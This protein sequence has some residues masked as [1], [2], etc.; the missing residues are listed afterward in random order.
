MRYAT[1]LQDQGS[2]TSTDSSRK[3]THTVQIKKIDQINDSI[4][5]FRLELPQNASPLRV[6]GLVLGQRQ[7]APSGRLG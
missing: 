6:C 2:D 1:E 4:R 5:V 7:T 3:A